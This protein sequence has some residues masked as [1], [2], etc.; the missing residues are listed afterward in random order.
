MSGSPISRNLW[1]RSITPANADAA[2]WKIHP[3][4]QLAVLE[5]INTADRL[6]DEAVP[7]SDGQRSKPFVLLTYCGYYPS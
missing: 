3:P 1:P 7:R 4:D 5:P 2:N 6:L